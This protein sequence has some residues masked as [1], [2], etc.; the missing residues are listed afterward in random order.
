MADPL[1]VAASIAGLL[2]AAAS[3]SKLLGPYVNAARD[4]PQIAYHVNDEVQAASIILSALQSLAQNMASVSAQRAALVE[5]DQVVAVLTNGVLIFSDLEASVSTLPLPDSSSITRLALRSRFQ[6]ARKETEF[7]TLLSRLQ[8]FKSSISLILGI[9]RSDTALQAQQH[10]AELE[11]SVN[12]L[13]ENSQELTRRLMSLEDTFDAQTIVTKR[14]SIA[15]SI[16]SKAESQR[17]LLPTSSF[18]FEDHLKTSGPYRRAK[19]D[20]MD[21]SFR[22]SVARSH[23]WSI[24]SGLSLGDISVMSVIA[25]PVYADEI[26]NSHHYEF[27]GQRSSVLP[28]T[29][30]PTRPLDDDSL[31]RR[32]LRV[33]FQLRQLPGLEVPS[34]SPP[35]QM[36]PLR[37]IQGHFQQGT[38]LLSLCHCFKQFGLEDVADRDYYP[39]ND[40]GKG[41]VYWALK[42]ISESSIFKPDEIPTIGQVL[43][44]DIADFLKVL[45]LIE[46][47][48]C[49]DNDLVLPVDLTVENTIRDMTNQPEDSV[50]FLILDDFTRRSWRLVQQLVGL[51]SHE[52]VDEL[53]ILTGREWQA[54]FKPML[55]IA[56]TELSFLLLAELNL[57]RPPWKRDW[58]MFSQAW[59][60]EADVYG[61]AIGSQPRNTKLLR[62]RVANADLPRTQAIAKALDYISLPSRLVEIKSDLLSTYYSEAP[63]SHRDSLLS[64]V[65]MTQQVM[66]RFQARIS[67]SAWEE[68]MLD[69]VTDLRSRVVDW[70][71]HKVEQFGKLQL[72]AEV[73]IELSKPN[74]RNLPYRIYLFDDMLFC[75][76]EIQPPKPSRIPLLQRGK[77]QELD[78]GR[79]LMPRGRILVSSITDM[80]H[81]DSSNSI[82]VTFRGTFQ[83]KKGGEPYEYNTEKP[84]GVDSGLEQ[85]QIKFKTRAQMEIWIKG[86][87]DARRTHTKVSDENGIFGWLK[88]GEG[89]PEDLSDPYF[90]DSE[91]N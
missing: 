68:E 90:E 47:I 13:L 52:L 64:D 58:S 65:T 85:F 84:F 74:S 41:R 49:L 77:P 33:E 80:L 75:C 32:C 73:S 25:L 61:H 35:Y 67:L 4:T 27:G 8:S 36:H 88:L 15:G 21:F 28:F 79:Q 48:L 1:S 54:I 59:V 83:K 71:G 44:H 14:R 69:V 19:R 31:L 39:L 86:L 53:E 22:S 50:D 76:S 3:I 72:H 20:T 30:T 56:E 91:S 38:P 45:D 12:Q 24:F 26:T 7:T 78:K 62:S 16:A 43:S 81:S 29:E 55:R 18:E 10:Q 60:A 11:S 9:L 66:E 87:E 34:L 63:T 51:T 5:V 42:A 46:R 40:G 6:W 70:K 17:L 57:L 23:V 82:K 37:A 89:A 2:S